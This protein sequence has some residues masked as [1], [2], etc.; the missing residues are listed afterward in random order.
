MLVC[1]IYGEITLWGFY[2]H[3]NALKIAVLCNAS[4]CVRTFADKATSLNP[5]SPSE[6]M[7]LINQGTYSGRVTGTLFEAQHNYFVS[8][9]LQ[10]VVENY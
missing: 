4:K 3:E 1:E 2:Y 5:P 8:T 7:E 10:P 9:V 6:T